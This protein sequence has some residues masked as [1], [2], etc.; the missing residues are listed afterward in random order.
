MKRIITM[1]IVAAAVAAPAAGSISA[2]SAAKPATTT[3]TRAER[4]VRIVGNIT[5][6]T[7]TKLVVKNATKKRSFVIPAGFSTA[8]FSVGDRV[9]A[10][11]KKIGGVLTLTSLKHEDRAAASTAPAGSYYGGASDA[12]RG[13]GN[14]DGPGHDRNDDHGNHGGGHA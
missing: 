14:D 7:A 11:G 3:V 2:A 6:L 9:Q 1:A 8:G 5:K 4:E 13:H 10:E 12:R